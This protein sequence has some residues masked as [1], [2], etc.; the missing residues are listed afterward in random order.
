MSTTVPIVLG[1]LLALALF[2]VLRRGGSA[3][4]QSGLAVALLIAA[5]IYVGFALSGGATG[6]WL[7]VEG[8]GV[9]LFSV[10]A[11]LGR[12][13]WPLL[14]AAGWAAHVAWDVAL[15][16]SGPAAG[17]TPSWYPW[18]CVGFDLALAGLITTL[19]RGRT[20]S[21]SVRAS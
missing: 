2:A 3:R 20:R 16:L 6:R 11:A 5:L 14:L 19:L 10:C 7:L 17:Y 13:R 15:H 21:T 9:V 18:L 12:R 4:T 8:A 1:A